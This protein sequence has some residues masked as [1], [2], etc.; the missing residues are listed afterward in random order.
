MLQN[1]N[2]P[3][4]EN[5][6]IEMESDVTDLDDDDD[7]DDAMDDEY[8]NQDEETAAIIDTINW[9]VNAVVNETNISKIETQISCFRLFWLCL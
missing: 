3:I 8:V 1:K 2:L 6:G 5:D 4:N 9:V 7:D